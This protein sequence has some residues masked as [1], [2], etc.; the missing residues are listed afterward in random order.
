MNELA[1]RDP[2]DF[3]ILDPFSDTGIAKTEPR[4]DALAT[5]SAGTKSAANIPSVSR[6]GK[7]VLHDP[8]NRATGLR[9]ALETTEY[10]R[11][12]IAFAFDDPS[13]F[14]QQRFAE[15]TASKL[16]HYG[17]QHAI[18]RI[19][20]KD[21]R[22]TMSA[23]TPEY[24]DALRKC[25]AQTS[26]YFTLATW[27]PEPSI[28]FPDGFGMYRLRFTS[29]N[30][31]QN[32]KAQ[33]NLVRKF[34]GGRLAGIPFDLY[35]QQRDVA[36]KDGSRRKVPVWSFVMR[37]PQSI[38]LTTK[39]FT[40]L[41]NNVLDV[42]KSLH[43]LPPASET[44]ELI[45]GEPQELDLDEASYEII[46]PS[47]EEKKRLESGFNPDE[48]RER[49]FAVVGNSPYANHPGRGW[50]IR[51]VLPATQSLKEVLSWCDVQVMEHLN[52]EA[53]VLVQQR[54]ALDAAIQNILKTFA[55]E[56]LFLPDEA[57]RAI[58]ECAYSYGSSY[59]LDDLQKLL[60]ILQVVKGAK[61]A[62]SRGLKDSAPIGRD[63]SASFEKPLGVSDGHC[64]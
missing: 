24:Q 61:K 8:E 58:A 40:Q 10:K 28:V 21:K 44:L 52:R 22:V 27:E 45:Q 32:L 12:T 30:T 2:H 1:T 39:N 29:R 16:V 15:Y 54:L 23:G 41:M 48:W 59:D 36:D 50:L 11:L 19:D 3:Q 31:M 38:S 6:D 14:I 49:F 47:Q 42:G 57:Q 13:Q 51:R 17:D 7:I 33:I 5:I 34:S 35:I 63:E 56:G 55:G 20:T 53:G 62:T 64:Q 43:M 46:E 25:K 26:L 18:T 60:G 4:L 37:P 9:E